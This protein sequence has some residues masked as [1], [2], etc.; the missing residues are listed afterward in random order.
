MLAIVVD[1]KQQE[2]VYQGL[3]KRGFNLFLGQQSLTFKIRQ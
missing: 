2:I 1:Q 3:E